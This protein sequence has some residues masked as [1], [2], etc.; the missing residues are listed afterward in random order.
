MFLFVAKAFS[1]GCV[2]DWGGGVC[3]GVCGC[4]G[5]KA[6]SFGTEGTYLAPIGEGTADL[7]VTNLMTDEVQ[8]A[9]S[10][11]GF[12]AGQRFWAQLQS[13]NIG[14][15]AE[16]WF[17]GNRVLDFSDYYLPP[18]A[19]ESYFL[20]DAITYDDLDETAQAFREFLKLV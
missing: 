12:S 16:Y 14:L 7:T 3:D 13:N 18:S 8:E 19:F 11:A 2:G 20:N 1:D 5:S 10:V 9:E 4:L 17:L 6:L 15:A